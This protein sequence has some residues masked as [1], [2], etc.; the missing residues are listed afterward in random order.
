MKVRFH[1]AKGQNYMK[2]Q[3]KEKNGLTYYYDPDQVNMILENCELH[4]SR[5]T[6]EGIFNGG[7]KTVCSWIECDRVFVYNA[8]GDTDYENQL[9]YNPRVKPNWVDSEGNN[10][11]GKRYDKIVT[12]GRKC[13]HANS[14]YIHIG[15]E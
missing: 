14:E 3:I 2:W 7:N 9:S 10:V 13:F 4:N 11:D 1:L 5:K 6:A 15:S 8:V 12:K